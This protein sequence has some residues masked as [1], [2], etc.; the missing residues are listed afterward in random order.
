MRHHPCKSKMDSVE[1]RV[2]VELFIKLERLRLFL[3][4]ERVSIFPYLDH[5]KLETRLRFELE[6]YDDRGAGISIVFG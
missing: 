6:V 2:L 1:L 3:I 5:H 4:I